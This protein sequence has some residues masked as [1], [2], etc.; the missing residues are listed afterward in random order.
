MWS[1][2]G[3]WAGN[4][5]VDQTAYL[6]VSYVEMVF[7]TSGS[8]AGYTGSKVKRDKKPGCRNVCVVDGVDVVGTPQKKAA[9]AGRNG[10]CVALL[11]GALVG[12]VMAAVV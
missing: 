11:V 7:N 12:A 8:I 6:D 9:A 10:V 3:V 1:D 2:G 4:M 5:T